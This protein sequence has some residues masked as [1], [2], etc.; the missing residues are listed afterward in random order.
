[1]LRKYGRTGSLFRRK[2]YLPD[3]AQ[4]PA[5]YKYAFSVAATNSSDEKSSFSTYNYTVDISAPGSNIYST[6]YNNSYTS[7]DGTS[8]SSPITAGCSIGS[9]ITVSHMITTCRLLNNLY[10]GR[11]YLCMYQ[12]TAITWIN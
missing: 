9:E 5:A 10:D 8:M 3:V 2:C 1:M 7:Y 4:Y 11:Q 12:A 6:V